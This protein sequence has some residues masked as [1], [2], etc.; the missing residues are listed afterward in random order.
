MESTN[1]PLGRQYLTRVGIGGKEARHRNKCKR[2]HRQDTHTD[3]PSLV[4]KMS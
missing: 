4:L 1:C 2:E 3:V